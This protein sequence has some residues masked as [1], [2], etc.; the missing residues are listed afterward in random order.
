MTGQLLPDSYFIKPF[1]AQHAVYLGIFLVV[2]ALILSQHRK[3]K[4]DAE[5][6]LATT[7]QETLIQ[8]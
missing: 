1:D 6:V 3:I 5:P 8:C 7:S 4:E 2:L